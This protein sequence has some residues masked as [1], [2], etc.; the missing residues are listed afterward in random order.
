MIKFI[1]QVI[2]IKDGSHYSFN[3]SVDTGI[4]SEYKRLILFDIACL[5][6]SELPFFIH[7]SLLFTNIEMDR[8]ENIIKLYPKLKKQFLYRLVELKN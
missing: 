7:D 5:K 6:L 1:L 2:T 8:A 4:G 3:T